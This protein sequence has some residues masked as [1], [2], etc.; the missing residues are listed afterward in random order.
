MESKVAVVHHWDDGLPTNSAGCCS[1]LK[2]YVF[3]YQ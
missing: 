2:A 1:V 3:E